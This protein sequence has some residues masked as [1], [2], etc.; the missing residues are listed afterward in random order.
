MFFGLIVGFSEAM[1]LRGFGY[2]ISTIVF[3]LTLMDH[4]CVMFV[5]W[6]FHGPGFEPYRFQGGITFDRL[7]WEFSAFFMN[8]CV[9]YLAYLF[10]YGIFSG[11]VFL[12]GMRKH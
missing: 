1:G 11:H 9:I 10:W 7:I 6:G 2:L 8:N 4:F 5:P 3:T 12:V